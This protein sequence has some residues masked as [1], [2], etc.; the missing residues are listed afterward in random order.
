MKKLFA[1]FICIS[2]FTGCKKTDDGN[3]NSTV[4]VVPLK[5]T[6]LKATVISTTQVD[7][8]WT[9]NSTNEIGFK[10]ERKT[11]NGNYAPIATI[12]KDITTYSDNG[13]TANTTYT[14]RLYAYNSA[15]NSL[16]YTNEVTV[17][18]NANIALATLTTTIVSSITETTAASGGNIT[19]DGGAS[20]NARG[21]VWSTSTN[22]TISLTTKTIDGPGIA[23]FTS[24]IT[25]LT[26]NTTYYVRAYAT[27][28][29]GTAYGNEVSFTTLSGGGNPGSIFN[30]NLTYGSVSDNDGNTYKTIQI[31]TQIWMAENLRTTKYRDGTTIPLV[32]DN[33]QWAS[34][35]NNTTLPMMCWYNNDPV[36][37]NANKFGALYN[38]YSI[39][40]GTNSNKNVCPTGW[41]IPSDD[42]WI[43]LT[44]FLGGESVAGG[45]MK[46]TGT[47]YWQSPNQDATN[48]SGFSG[49]PVGLRNFD[50]SFLYVGDE[51]R[52]WSSTEYPAGLAWVR[53]LRYNIANLGRGNSSKQCGFS[54]R[55]L[56]D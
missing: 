18:T 4:T 3:G 44:T 54:V 56:K 39:N 21:V 43:T 46:S 22:P 13:L 29:A 47:Q 20:V 14:Y 27:N 37:Y 9:D 38:W 5:P 55:C 33:T 51:G 30:P 17:T 25:G 48:S 49:L 41:H 53:I 24:S 2:L 28:S 40:P 36:T 7:L 6:E 26:A 19:S 42:E 31:G 8:S 12:N 16:G 10:L 50:G 35:L 52:W 1:A 45:K 23:N 11:G 32:T 34:N 15:G